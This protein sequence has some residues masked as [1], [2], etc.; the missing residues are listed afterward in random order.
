MKIIISPAKSLDFEREIPNFSFEHP[1]YLEQSAKIMKPLKRIKPKKLGELMKIS[2]KLSELNWERNQDWELD[3]SASSSRPAVYAFTGDVYQGIDV[4]HLSQEQV[5]YLQENLNILS[6]L[7]GMLRPLDFIL[8]YRLEMGTKLPVGKAKNLYGFWKPILTPA[9]NDAFTEEGDFLLNLASNEY[10]KALDLKNMNVPVIT[11]Q[12]Q[13]Y[14]DG[15]LKMISFFAKKARGL[16]VRYCALN[17]VSTIDQ[18][19]QFDLDGYA[20]DA[21][22]SDETN[23]VFT[24]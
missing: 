8:P 19:K 10:S 5:G 6:G 3:Y 4:D 21:S 15:K 1:L 18:I 11:P 12:F 7:Y 24:R 23:L 9:M 2:D 16:M 13:D 22:L 14:K 20:L 17:K